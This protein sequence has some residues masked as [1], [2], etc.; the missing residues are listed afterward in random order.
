M[1]QHCATA[2]SQRD[3]YDIACIS[4]VSC[5][6]SKVRGLNF[7]LVIQGRTEESISIVGI[8][9]NSAFHLHPVPQ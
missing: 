8:Q 9:P 7:R 4:H 2:T 5:D 6:M 1:V 3:P